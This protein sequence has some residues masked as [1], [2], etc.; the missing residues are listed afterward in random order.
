MTAQLSSSVSLRLLEPF[1]AILAGTTETTHFARIADAVFDRLLQQSILPHIEDDEAAPIGTS[2]RHRLLRTQRA[3]AEPADLAGCVRNGAPR[4]VDADPTLVLTLDDLPER[5]FAVASDPYV[6]TPPSSPRSPSLCPLRPRAPPS[7]CR[8]APTSLSRVR[9][10]PH[11]L[12]RRTTQKHRRRLYELQTQL[13]AYL[14]AAAAPQPPPAVEPAQAPATKP[15]V[16][17]PAPATKPAAPA[18][19]PTPTAA[20]P[21]PKQRKRAAADNAAAE[22]AAPAPPAPEPVAV[23]AASP[24]SSEPKRRKLT[25]TL[26]AA[27]SA[28]PA[29]AAAPVAEEAS[30]PLP[31]AD[32][33]TPQTK[34]K[35]AVRISLEDSSV[36]RT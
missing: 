24:A 33:G 19:E 11:P 9:G 7:L 20:K 29:P 32:Q 23:A 35:R 16:P 18:A 15:A 14:K 27:I 13:E 2:W 8:P 21:T 3:A 34:G 22:P 25:P 26:I 6:P 30:S 12:C 4:A 31:T 1:L 36:L 17:A 10:H 28:P 5:L